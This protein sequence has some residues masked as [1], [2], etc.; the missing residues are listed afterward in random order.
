MKYIIYSILFLMAGL[1]IT[2]CGDSDNLKGGFAEGTGGLNLKEPSTE[3]EID[4]PVIYTRSGNIA[5]DLQPE[6]FPVSIYKKGSETSVKSFESFTALIDAGTPLV[7]PVG[8]YTVK[9]SSFTPSEKV[10][11]KPYFDGSTDFKIE[12]GDVLNTSVKCFFKSLGVELRLSDRFKELLAAQPENYDYTVTVSNEL[13]TWTFDKKEMKT[14]YFLDGCTRLIV[15]VVVKMGGQTYPERTWY[16]KNG[17]NAP[18][19][20]EYYIITL[21]AGK[22]ELKMS[23]YKL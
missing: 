21:D 10:S 5:F 1:G 23:S 4:I 13:A 12:E 6:T 14:G 20:G 8:E 17:E 2:G 7:L 22:N 11:E 18:Q 19:I 3:K 9:A 16:F 15:K